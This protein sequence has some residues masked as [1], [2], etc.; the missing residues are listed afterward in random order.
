MRDEQIA[1]LTT[2]KRGYNERFLRMVDASQPGTERQTVPLG[3]DDD[4]KPI[5]AVCWRGVKNGEG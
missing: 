5:V 4:G 2:K 1:A 3:I